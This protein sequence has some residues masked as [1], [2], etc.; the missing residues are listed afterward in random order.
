MGFIYI[1]MYTINVGGTTF[2]GFNGTELME[3]WPPMRRM[4]V[5]WFEWKYNRIY[6]NNRDCNREKEHWSS[7]MEF[8]MGSMFDESSI[9]W[10]ESKHNGCPKSWETDSWHLTMAHILSRSL[11][12]ISAKTNMSSYN[13]CRILDINMDDMYIYILIYAYI[14]IANHLDETFQNH[15]WLKGPGRVV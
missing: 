1:Y 6:L 12:N 5:S 10:Q 13:S 14:Y 9:P 11:I 2:K 8:N 4:L 15:M 3:I 7:T